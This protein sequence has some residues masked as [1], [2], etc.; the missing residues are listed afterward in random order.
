MNRK[1]K[2]GPSRLLLHLI[3]ILLCLI[4][5]IPL[6]LVVGISFTDETSLMVD[7]YHF[8][9]RVF[10]ADA[11]KYVFSGAGSVLQAYVVTIAVTVLGTGLHLLVTSMLGLLPDEGRGHCTGK[12]ILV[13]L[14]P[15]AVQRR[16]GSLLYA[17]DP[18]PAS[19]KYHMGTDTCQ[20]GFGSE[21]TDYEKLFPDDTEFSD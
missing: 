9:P 7:G 10:S 4:C 6:L 15:G 19:E 16:S 20:P 8:I 18:F 21:C 3:F 11:Y 2:I 5:V 13:C 17:D 12:N 14:H 1:K